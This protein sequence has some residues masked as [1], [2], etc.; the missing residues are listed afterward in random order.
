[1]SAIELACQRVFALQAAQDRL[2][3]LLRHRGQEQK[4][5]R[6]GRVRLARASPK[7]H[8][9]PIPVQLLEGVLRK[10]EPDRL[11]TRRRAVRNVESPACHALPDCVIPIKPCAANKRCAR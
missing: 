7:K 1:M 8:H 6:L 11:R 5:G 4:R 3:R 2:R 9:F 10:I